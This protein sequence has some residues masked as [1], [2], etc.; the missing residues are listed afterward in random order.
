MESNEHKF[1]SRTVQAVETACEII[2]NLQEMDEAGITELA[3]K[4]GLSKGAVHS[5]LATLRKMQFVTKEG[6][7]YRPSL[8][9]LDLGEHVKNRIPI[10]DVVQTEIEQ[11]AE[12]TETRAQFLMEE[13]GICVCVCIA[14]GTH[15]VTPATRVGKRS[16]LH[17]A[18]GGKSILAHLS[19]DRLDQILDQHGL[20]AL[21]DNTITDRDELM[22]ELEEVRESNVGLNDEEKL[23]GL[24]AV[25]VP[26][27][28]PEGTI[29]GAVSVSGTTSKL[30]DE[31]FYERLPEIVGN[32]ANVIEIN[33]QIQEKERL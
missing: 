32:T 20:P 21:T 3:D 9:F 22:D 26:I 27:R 28:G 29:Y 15:A 12:E 30:N 8:R 2:E 10:Y 33:A 6:S 7:T 16:Y 13:H 18:A 31:L 4:T 1:E 14:R 11:L 25:G 23:Q 5:H 24:R 19:E 17:C